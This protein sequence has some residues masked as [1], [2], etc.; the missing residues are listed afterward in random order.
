MGE[1]CLYKELL[2]VKS[3]YAD[4]LLRHYKKHAF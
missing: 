3:D 4:R 1:N 2:E